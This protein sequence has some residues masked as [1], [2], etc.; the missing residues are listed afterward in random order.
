M[1]RFCRH[2]ATA[3]IVVPY[4]RSRLSISPTHPT[5]HSHEANR[6]KPA[7]IR[8]AL[9]PSGLTKIRGGAS[10]RCRAGSAAKPGGF[11]AT[12]WRELSA[13]AWGASLRLGWAGLSPVLIHPLGEERSALLLHL[14]AVSNRHNRHRLVARAALSACLCDLARSAIGRRWWRWRLH[15]AEHVIMHAGAWGGLA[16]QVALAPS[17]LTPVALL[18]NVILPAA[19][20]PVHLPTGRYPQYRDANKYK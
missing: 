6:N 15:S 12:G 3:N 8:A 1:Q 2:P 4:L 7:K 14:S 13:S 9:L 17:P 19:S 18:R 20:E 5:N 10:G 16:R 11:D